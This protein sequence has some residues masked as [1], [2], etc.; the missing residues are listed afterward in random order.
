[1]SVLLTL[2]SCAIVAAVSL[3]ST[4]LMAVAVAKEDEYEQLAEKGLETKF[5][6][7]KILIKALNGFDCHDTVVSENEIHVKTTAGSMIYKRETASEPFRLYLENIS[8]V[9]AL[10]A[11]IRSFEVDYQRNVQAYTYDHIKKNLPDGMTIVEDEI[12]D[13]DSIVV[14]VN[15]E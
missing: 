2:T 12:L 7:D 15:V 5:A 6:D 8:D 9:D 3:S 11:D 13:D 4:A 14:T 10:V 1:M